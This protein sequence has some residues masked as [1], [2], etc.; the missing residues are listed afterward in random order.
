MIREFRSKDETGSN[1]CVRQEL[2]GLLPQEAEDL[3]AHIPLEDESGKVKL[4]NK[5]SKHWTPVHL[6][7]ARQ[8]VM[9]ACEGPDDFLP[10]FQT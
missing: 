5:A 2:A 1:I 9:C 6:N 7:R 3:V 8:R 4:E 10:A